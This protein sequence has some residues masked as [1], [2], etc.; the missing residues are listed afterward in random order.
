MLFHPITSKNIIIKH[1]QKKKISP[2]KSELPLRIQKHTEKE[3]VE[4][5]TKVPYKGENKNTH[6]ETER[7][8]KENPFLEDGYK[9]F[10]R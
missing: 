8:V 4:K 7:E 5:E 10:G 9:L 2:K 3:K 6:T 1:N